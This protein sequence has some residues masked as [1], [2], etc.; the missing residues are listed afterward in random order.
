MEP[1]TK[2]I[3]AALS[4][5]F[6]PVGLVSMLIAE[7]DKDLAYHGAQG[8]T[9]G[10]LA[11]IALWLLGILVPYGAFMLI[12]LLWLG[13]LVLAIVYALKAYKGEQF[14]IPI[15]YDVMQKVR[16]A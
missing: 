15:V 3:L 2:Q 5:P 14:R 6:W 8:L 9:F 1:S 4:Y 11:C 7:K 16:K 13:F 10:L 12:Q